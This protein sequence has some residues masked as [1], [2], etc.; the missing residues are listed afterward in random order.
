MFPEIKSIILTDVNKSQH[1]MSK[2]TNNNFNN[3]ENS[4]NENL[5]PIKPP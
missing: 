3:S 4:E 5:P 2:Q 1:N